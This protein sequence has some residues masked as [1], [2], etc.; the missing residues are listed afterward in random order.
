MHRFRSETLHGITCESPLGEGG[1]TEHEAQCEN[2]ISHGS[3]DDVWWIKTKAN[4]TATILPN[5]RV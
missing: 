2:G 4:G 3:T 5:A 1:Q